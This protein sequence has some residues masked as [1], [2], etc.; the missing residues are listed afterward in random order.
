[1]AWSPLLSSLARR[2]DWLLML[3]IAAMASASSTRRSS[4]DPLDDERPLVV[5]ADDTG[6]AMMPI[7][8]G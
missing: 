8:G 3:D 7:L 2:C 4:L 5:D 1:M 6:E